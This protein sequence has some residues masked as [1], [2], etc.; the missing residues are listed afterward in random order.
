MPRLALP[1]NLQQTAD[2]ISGLQL[3]SGAVPWFDGGITD[4]WDHVEALMGLTVAGHHSRALKGFQWLANMQRDDGA[5]FAAYQGN[6]VADNSRAETNFVAY[7][8]TG[9][10]HYYLATNDHNT[11]ETYWPMLQSA[12]EFVL[13]QQAPTGEIYW[14]VDSK[15]GTSKDALVTGCSAIYKSL[16]CA[17]HVADT[18]KESKPAW[19]EAR[20]RLGSA[21]RNRPERFDR[22][23]EPKERYSMDW[24][25]P[26][27]AGVI[28]G[29]L[30]RQRLATKW[31]VFVEP[32]LGCRCVKD[33]PWVTVAETC[34]LIIACVVA[35]EYERALAMY[36]DIQRFQLQDGSWWTGY[37]FTDDAYWP[38]EKPSWTA[39]AVLLAADI[40]FD[41]TPASAL[42]KTVEPEVRT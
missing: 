4:P 26:V 27:L 3:P 16:A 41:F 1:K 37:V 33:Q 34:E 9:L 8:A 18:L 38:D 32:E 40:L 31:D 29:D 13:R 28:H 23:W 11:L 12:I 20:S 6:E 15:T 25:Y 36:N 14:A 19:H 7:V 5:W 2:Y 10:W 42:F 24:F 39:G 30:A 21:I 22:T 35:G 17:G